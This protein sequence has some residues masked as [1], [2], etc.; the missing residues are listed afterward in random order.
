MYITNTIVGLIWY[1]DGS[2]I[3][4]GTG[5]YYDRTGRKRSFGVGH[6]TTVFQAE[7]YAIKVCAV[8]NLDRNYR[9]RNI[10]ILSDSQAAIKALGTHQRI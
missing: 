1:T 2:K 9:N 4:K 5:V 6:Y 3:N 10:C 8:E 7:M